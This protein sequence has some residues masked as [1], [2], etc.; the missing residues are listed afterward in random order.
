MNRVRIG[1][2]VGIL[3]RCYSGGNAESFDNALIE[4]VKIVSRINPSVIKNIEDY[5]INLNE[6]SF[7]FWGVDQTYLGGYYTSVYYKKVNIG[8]PDGFDHF[9]LDIPTLELVD[10]TFNTGGISESDVEITYL[11]VS[12]DSGVGGPKGDKEDYRDWETDRKSTRL[13]SSH[14][15]KARMPSSA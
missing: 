15:A 11:N 3:V 6:I 9:Y 10:K 7:N 12:G 5:S 8:A 2:N 13:N 1:Q 14:S 4:Y